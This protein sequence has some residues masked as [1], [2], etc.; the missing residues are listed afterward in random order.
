VPS[1]SAAAS[2]A[3]LSA[4]GLPVRIC[5]N[6]PAKPVHTSMSAGRQA[7][8]SAD[9]VVEV[10]RAGFVGGSNS[11]E[12]GAMTKRVLPYSAEVRTSAACPGPAKRARLAMGGDPPRLPRRSAARARPCATVCGRPN[13]TRVFGRVRQPKSASASRR[14]SARTTSCVRQTR[15]CAR[16]RHI[17][18]RRSST[19]GSSHDRLHR[20]APRHPRV[21]P[22]CRVLPI[23]PSTY[24]AHTD[25]RAD[26]GKLP[27]RPGAMP[28]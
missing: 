4:T 2:S 21:E 28:R 11:G 22:I 8:S 7:A 1:P 5:T 27:A 23:A 3:A 18:T 19:A 10:N 17:L 14:S 16:R 6:R 26:P 9:P 13:V 24:Y 15:S 25:P 20:R 12:N